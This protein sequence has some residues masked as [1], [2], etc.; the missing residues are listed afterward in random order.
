MPVCEKPNV[1]VHAKVGQVV[2]E[3]VTVVVVVVGWVVVDLLVVVVAVVEVVVVEPAVADVVE[4]VL[5]VARMLVVDDM[6]GTVVVVVCPPNANRA[7][8]ARGFC[9]FT[10]ISPMTVRQSGAMN[11]LR[12]T[13]CRLPHIPQRLVIRVPFD[14]TLTRPRRSGHSWI[15]TSRPWTTMVSAGG[16]SGSETISSSP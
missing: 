13:R 7:R 10:P 5:V 16:S 4:E 8:K 3:P 12:R 9:P 2:V 15:P 6:R 14:V 1:S 11:T